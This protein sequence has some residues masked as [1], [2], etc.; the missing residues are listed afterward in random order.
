MFPLNA[1]LS[2]FVKD[3]RLKVT[4]YDGQIYEYGDPNA[5][6]DAA[7]SLRDPDTARKLAFNPP[8]KLGELYMDGALTIEEGSLI[9][10]L[11][12]LLLNNRRWNR[13]IWGKVYH[14]A[15]DVV[16]LPSVLN[17]ASRARK[18][19][20]HHYDLSDEL[21]SLFLDSDRQYS[22]AYFRSDDADI[23]TAQLNKRQHIA[24]KLNI[25]P[26]Q[27]VLDIGSGWGGLALYLAQHYPV[28]VTGLT[29]SDEQYRTSNARARELGLEDRVE[30]K[31]L[32]YRK[33]MG[34]YDRIVSV[35]MFE[36]V[37]KPYFSAFFRKL[38]SLLTPE[39]FALIHTIGSQNPPG[40]INPWLRRYIF[41]G[42]YLP[43]LSQLTP[44]F[45]RQ[46]LWLTDMESL[47]LHYAKTLAAWNERFQANRDR[48]A[49]LYDERFCRMWEFYLQSCEAG[50]RWSGLT[51]FQLQLS[52]EIDAVPITRD[53]MV[54]EEDRLRELDRE[55]EE[56]QDDPSRRPPQPRREEDEI[57]SPSTH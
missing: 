36:H 17:F 39:G 12:L 9:G 18:N 35:G 19:V 10:F 23:E 40:P 11:R 8:L 25:Q 42:A 15:E 33:E 47:R 44:I 16:R 48:V 13:S 2:Q 55:S 3:G 52:R 45:E 7:I 38:Q 41:P 27:H 21:F 37:G 29:L 54:R 43:S 20:K 53:Y 34:S 4:D 14:R 1:I 56:R 51:V 26:D 57:R 31:L 22:C 28:K 32:D 49:N 5:Q 24:A 6:L 50:F 46:G 30:F